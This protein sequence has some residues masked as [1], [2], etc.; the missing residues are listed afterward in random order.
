MPDTSVAK[1]YATNE[2]NLKEFEIILELIPA[3]QGMIREN[4]P[5]EPVPVTATAQVAQ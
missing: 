5:P 2:R 4:I 3:I 1:A